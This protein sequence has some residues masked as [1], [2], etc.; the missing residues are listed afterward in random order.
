VSGIL[1]A[2]SAVETLDVT[3]ETAIDPTTFDWRA[4]SLRRN[5][6]T[7]LITAA[8]TVMQLTE[9]TYR[10][11]GLTGLTALRG[12][13]ELRVEACEL[14]DLA[15]NSGVGAASVSW[16]NV[17]LW[18]TATW[19]ESSPNPSQHG[20]EVTL[21]SRVTHAADD[22]STPAGSVTFRRGTEVLGVCLALDRVQ[23]GEQ[24]LAIIQALATADPL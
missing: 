2:S 23:G 4:L 15:G 11:G 24:A 22:S 5:G 14:N 1:F 7:E 21:T 12:S 9:L 3:F 13:Y 17:S 16:Q 8:V 6:G 18:T 10:I 19:L 20:E